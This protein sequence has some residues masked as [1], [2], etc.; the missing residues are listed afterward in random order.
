[1]VRWIE[2]REYNEATRAFVESDKVEGAAK[3]SGD[4]DSAEA[5]SAEQ[6]GLGRAKEEDP[7][8]HR[9]YSKPAE[10]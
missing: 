5:E 1:M 7:A 6:A 10:D 8:L 9:D 3:R 2:A 4:Q